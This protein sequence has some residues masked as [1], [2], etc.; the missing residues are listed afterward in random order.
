MNNANN[1][2]IALTAAL[3]KE[4]LNKSIKTEKRGRKPRI[5]SPSI[6][7]NPRAKFAVNSS[8]KDGVDFLNVI[9]SGNT[10]LG[11]FLSREWYGK[12]TTPMGE[13]A[14][15]ELYAAALNTPDLPSS[16]NTNTAPGALVKKILRHKLKKIVVP[17]YWSL[18]LMGMYYKILGNREM[19]QELLRSIGIPTVCFYI[20]APKNGSTSELT[21][22]LIKYRRNMKRYL[23]VVDLVRTMFAIHPLANDNYARE[24]LLT[25]TMVQAKDAPDKKLDASVPFSCGNPRGKEPDGG[26]NMD[27]LAAEYIELTKD[28]S[29]QPPVIAFE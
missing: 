14:S 3:N 11:K 4:M 21:T 7:G 27:E 26:F 18:I 24:K 10:R 12:F 2:H 19:R 28:L 15:M 17:N 16:F 8:M 6:L 5:E 22:S 9:V 1:L 13:W 25:V 20:S 29:T 23:M